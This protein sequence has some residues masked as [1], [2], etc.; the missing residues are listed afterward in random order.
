MDLQAWVFDLG[1]PQTV[2]LGITRLNCRPFRSDSLA[3][4]WK[5][6]VCVWGHACAKDGAIRIEVITGVAGRR[7]W[8]VQEKLRIVEEG[9]APGGSVSAVAR[10]N[11]V[12][13]NLPFRWREEGSENGPADRFPRRK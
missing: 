2:S 13:P 4:P 8:L 7:Y 3:E 10:R 1:G 9:S 5:A 11:S 6:Q 12:A